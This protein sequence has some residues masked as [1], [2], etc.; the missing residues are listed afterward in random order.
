MSKSY[1]QTSRDRLALNAF[2]ALPVIA[3]LVLIRQLQKMGDSTP[4]SP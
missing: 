2:I 1:S 3:A 4:S